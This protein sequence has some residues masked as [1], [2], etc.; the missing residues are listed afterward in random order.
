MSKIGYGYGS[1]WHLLRYLGYHRNYLSDEIKKIIDCDNI[2]WFDFK[3][4]TEGEQLHEEE[5]YKSINIFTKSIYDNVKD[6]WCGFWP[7][8]GNEQRWDAAGYL[9]NKENEIYLVVE[10]K[11]HSGEIV[12]PCKAKDKDSIDKI[13]KAI[14]ETIKNLEVVL[15]P[16]ERD[17]WTKRYYQFANR[18]AF[19][20][21]CN[22]ILNL[23]VILI[24]LYFIGD[25]NY[26][27]ICPKTK[28]EWDIFMNSAKTEIGLSNIAVSKQ[29]RNCPKS[30]DEWEIIINKMKFEMGLDN[31]KIPNQ[32]DLFLHINPYKK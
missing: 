24:N 16:N 29:S 17:L 12:S 4:N 19:L 2:Q 26:P 31:I 7:C 22:N 25:Y 23:K 13:S 6:D 5:E 32:Y 1:E 15:T 20:Y 3:F 30:K 28:R 27:F 9:K 10:A 14:D 18:L 21:F 8:T 11:G